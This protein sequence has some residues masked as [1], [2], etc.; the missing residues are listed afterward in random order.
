MGFKERLSRLG[1]RASGPTAPA[2]APD[3]DAL[4]AKMQE[5]LESELRPALPRSAHFEQRES[6]DSSSLPFVVFETG[7]GPVARRLLRHAPSHVVGR[8]S[9]QAARLADAH[10]LSLLALSPEWAEVD[11]SR[12][13]FFD[14]ETTGLG[15]AGSLAFLVGLGWFDESG[16]LVLEQLLLEEPGQEAAL[17]ERVTEVFSGASALVSFN[18]KSFDWPLLG[19]R[20]VMNRLP[21]WPALP[22]L[23]LLHVA[24][25]VHKRRLSR[26]N[27]K[28]LEAEVLGFDRSADDI[29]G[30]DIPARYAHYL[31]TGDAEALRPVV[32]HNAWD[33]VSMAALVALYGEPLSDA[34]APEGTPPGTELLGPLDL[35][36]LAETFGRA[37]AFEAALGAVDRA[38]AT[39]P[40]PDALRVRARL[41]KSRG[42][43]ARALG[44]FLALSQEVDDPRVRLELVK[45]YE[46]HEKDFARALELLAAGTGEDEVKVERR[47]KRL[48]SRA[49]ASR[50]H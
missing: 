26:T 27:L 40:S 28:T 12:I 29:S 30:A 10:V 38:L 5:L 33:V 21:A 13:V 3:L 47:R 8:G 50:R 48:E 41:H 23:D 9:T 22:H 17:L 34:L 11:L 1:P 39:D 25:R 44:D 20:L 7:C 46:H 14:T 42:D 18:G 31:R 35:L 36:G 19:A 37:R 16:C 49:R 32:D 24:R 4:R 15:G 43:R 45:L 2:E 6:G